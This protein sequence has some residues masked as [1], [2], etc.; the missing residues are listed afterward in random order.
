MHWDGRAERLEPGSPATS[1][2]LHPSP[3][4]PV[5]QPVLCKRRKLFSH[6]SHIVLGF[7]EP[8]PDAQN[9]D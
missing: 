7:S 1:C 5:S 2:S 6:L 3:P 8:N 4:L 9:L